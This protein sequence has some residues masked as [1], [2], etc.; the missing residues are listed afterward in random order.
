MRRDRRGDRRGVEPPPWRSASA[1]LASSGGGWSS[2]AA[3]RPCA[4]TARTVAGWRAAESRR[5]RRARGPALSGSAG[6]SASSSRRVT[7][8][9][10]QA[11]LLL[12]NVDRWRSAKSSL[13]SALR[14]QARARAGT[15]RRPAP[16]PPAGRRARPPSCSQANSVPV[17]PSPVWISSATSA[18]PW[19]VQAAARPREIAGR[20]RVRAAPALDRLDDERGGLRAVAGEPRVQRVG[21]AVGHGVE[22]R[23]QRPE[24][25]SVFGLAARRHRARTSTRGS[26]PRWTARACAPS[27][28]AP[29]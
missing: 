21:V 27:R 28:R 14:R 13:H 9:A 25:V 26:R 16:W 2:I 8:P 18:T 4:R 7:S 29:A 20:R 23:R 19:R 22:P 5:A 15:A 3:S 11:R 6:N 1:G 24:A 17:R 12:A 10:R